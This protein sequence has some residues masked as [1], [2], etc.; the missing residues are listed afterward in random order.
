MALGVLCPEELR[1]QLARERADKHTD[2][3]AIALKL[4]MP[5]LYVPLLFDARYEN[6]IQKAINKAAPGDKAK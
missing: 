5:Q 3:Y 1:Q 4:R 2:D 6:L